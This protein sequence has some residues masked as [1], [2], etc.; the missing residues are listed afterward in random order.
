VPA[1]A[2]SSARSARFAGPVGSAGADRLVEYRRLVTA[3]AA[4]SARRVADLEAA[5]RAYAAGT[6]EAEAELTALTAAA[7]HAE[8]WAAGAAATVVAV[9]SE[10]DRLWAELRRAL[11][12]R[13]VLLGDTPAPGEP[14][15]DASGPVLLARAARAVDALRPDSSRRDPQRRDQQRRDQQRRRDGVRRRLPWWAVTL[16]PGL[17]AAVAATVALAAGGLVTL[18]QAGGQAGEAMRM[19][20]YLTFLF[21]PFTG[22]PAAAAMAGRR[23]GGR[24][25]AGGVALTVLGGMIAGS[26]I[27]LGLR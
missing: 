5:E 27:A 22:L 14:D 25:D 20:G 18:G 12:W 19:L 2:L 13:G 26:A 8:R 17:G 6:A 4:A 9:D 3:L 16:L 15:R 24:L 11:G 21:A 23:F 10:A 7:D 1:R